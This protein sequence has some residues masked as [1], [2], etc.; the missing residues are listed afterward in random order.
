MRH[1]SSMFSFTDLTVVTATLESSKWE[2]RGLSVFVCLAG[3]LGAE[4]Y[5]IMSSQVLFKE[6]LWYMSSL[7]LLPPLSSP[8]PI[9]Q[10]PLNRVTFEVVNVGPLLRHLSRAQ[11]WFVF[12]AMFN[13]PFLLSHHS[14]SVGGRG[15]I[16]KERSEIILDAKKLV[17]NF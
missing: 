15:V 9:P 17:I 6:P 8:P 3:Q 12:W 5:S 2:V 7:C 11:K 16:G 1:F 13:V 14:E 4:R 10:A